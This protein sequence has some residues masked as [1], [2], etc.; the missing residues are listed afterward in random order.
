MTYILRELDGMYQAA[1]RRNLSEEEL[2]DLFSPEKVTSVA[3]K[4]QPS[5]EENAQSYMQRMAPL[6][7]A[8]NQVAQA[9]PGQSIE[10]YLQEHDLSL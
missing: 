5:L 6:R 2:A 8:F 10:D 4:Y 1:L 3:L 9:K 7:D